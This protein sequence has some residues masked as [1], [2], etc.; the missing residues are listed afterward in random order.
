MKGNAKI[1]W[2]FHSPTDISIVGKTKQGTLICKTD[3]QLVA[4]DLRSGLPKWRKQFDL[5]HDDEGK[6]RSISIVSDTI[7][8][9]DK[10]GKFHLLQGETGNHF[11]I[12]E[13]GNP[14][15]RLLSKGTSYYYVVSSDTL[16]CYNPTIQAIVW[17]FEPINKRE[18]SGEATSEGDWVDIEGRPQYERPTWGKPAHVEWIEYDKIEEFVGSRLVMTYIEWSMVWWYEPDDSLS[19]AN[20][21]LA[22]FAV[23][24]ATTGSSI[25]NLD[26]YAWP[27]E[28]PKWQKIDNSHIVLPKESGTMSCMNVFTQE[29]SW[30]YTHQGSKNKF[31]GLYAKEF[32]TETTIHDGKALCV[33]DGQE[34]VVLNVKSGVLEH[35]FNPHHTVGELICFRAGI[36]NI[37][38]TYRYDLDLGYG[39]LTG[40]DLNRG[41]QLW[42][43]KIEELLYHWH[44]RPEDR[45]YRR[46][47]GGQLV[48]AKGGTI[49]EEVSSGVKQVVILDPR[50]GVTRA[51]H[52]FEEEVSNVHF[53]EGALFYTRSI[54]GGQTAIEAIRF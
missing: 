21:P 19:R 14:F 36:E 54:D 18:T 39:L 3:N 7:A 43:L 31:T 35:I 27:G 38:V 6:G 23:L 32:A 25:S 41:G 5:S 17:T 34:I 29:R 16:I 13:T 9:G 48:L 33:F 42:Q 45:M 24:E 22:R 37:L 10:T 53:Y 11:G 50:S 20:V 12:V 28:T 15:P 51:S 2:R 26:A 4:L 46:H 52:R 30:S 8:L 49:D 44:N 47:S 1:Q 40:Y